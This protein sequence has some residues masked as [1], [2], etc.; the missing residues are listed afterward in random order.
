MHALGGGGEGRAAVYFKAQVEKTIKLLKPE[1][2]LKCN[3]VH[4]E[5]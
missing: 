4:S 2:I 5:F 1:I 3:S